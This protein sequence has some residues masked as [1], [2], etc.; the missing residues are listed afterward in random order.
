M[1]CDTFQTYD[2][3]LFKVK[4]PLICGVNGYCLG[5]GFVNNFI[6]KLI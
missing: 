6:F 3:V 1:I 2:N 5:G 4:K